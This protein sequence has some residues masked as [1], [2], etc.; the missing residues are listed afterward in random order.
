MYNKFADSYIEVMYSLHIKYDSICPIDELVLV[1]KSL[2]T[3]LSIKYYGSIGSLLIILF[4]NDLIAFCFIIPLSANIV[5][6]TISIH[7]GSALSRR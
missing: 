4:Y 5:V 3:D 6:D 1:S 2:A 7:L